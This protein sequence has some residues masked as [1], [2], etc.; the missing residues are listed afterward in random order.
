M[1]W[2]YTTSWMAGGLALLV[3]GVAVSAE[4]GDDAVA[5]EVRKGQAM[6]ER[7]C[8]R[9][10][11]VG[12]T[13]ES[14]VPEAPPFRVFSSLWPLTYLEEALAEGIMVG[15]PLAEMPVFQFTP[16]EISHLIRY[17]ETIQEQESWAEEEG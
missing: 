14:P 15:H 16:T 7:L 1:R 3:S 12:T 10:H 11:A 8:S 2:K 5:D 13:G 6:A 17:M 4:P 9:C